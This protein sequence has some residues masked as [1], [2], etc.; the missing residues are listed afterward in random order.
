MGLSARQRVFLQLVAR[1]YGPRE[2]AQETQYSWAYVYAEL[3]DARCA[4]G[5]RTNAAAIVEGLRFGFIGMPLPEEMLVSE[6][7]GRMHAG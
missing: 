7:H 1:G 5:V 6:A 3:R 2:I 4:L